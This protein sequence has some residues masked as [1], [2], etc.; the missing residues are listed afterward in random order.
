[1]R[2]LGIAY[3]GAAPVS[4]EGGAW[5]LGPDGVRHPTRGTASAPV[6]PA[7]PVPGSPVDRLLGAV[8]RFHSELA[9]DRE[10]SGKGSQALLSLHA[11]VTL[12]LRGE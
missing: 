9:F 2:A 8:G 1:M 11:R 6:W 4:A 3:L 12:G 5:T 7:L 10:G